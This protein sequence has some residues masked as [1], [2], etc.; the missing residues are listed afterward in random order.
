MT[1][2]DAKQEPSVAAAGACMCANMFCIAQ[3]L[4]LQYVRVHGPSAAPGTVKGD[5][6]A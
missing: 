1:A 6:D 4:D 3:R 5:A 2:Q